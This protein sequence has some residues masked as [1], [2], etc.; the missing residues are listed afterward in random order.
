M[1]GTVDV[2]DS[3]SMSM[4]EL[5]YARPLPVAVDLRTVYEYAAMSTVFVAGTVPGLFAP[6][7]FRPHSHSEIRLITLATALAQFNDRPI[8]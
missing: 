1:C 6:H 5:F 7:S 2:D 8:K 3:P 4:N